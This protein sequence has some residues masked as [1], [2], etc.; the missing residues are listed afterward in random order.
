MRLFG[1]VFMMLLFPSAS[2]ATWVYVPPNYTNVQIGAW[3]S[4]LLKW[5]NFLPVGSPDYSI[6]SGAIPIITPLSKTVPFPPLTADMIIQS[7][8]QVFAAPVA[9]NWGSVLGMLSM[10]LTLFGLSY[11]I[12]VIARIFT[13]D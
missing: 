2:Y 13:K 11:G 10:V 8:A 7:N 9:V 12:G 1:F 5:D 4:V 6:T 3:D